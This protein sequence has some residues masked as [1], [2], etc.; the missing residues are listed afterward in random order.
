ML[1]PAVTEAVQEIQ[2]AFSIH[3]IVVD[4][5][6]DGGARVLVEDL[7]IGSPYRQDKSWMGFHI[8]FPYPS[9]D[10]YPHF[11]RAD[12]ARVDGRPLGDGLSGGQSFLGRPSVQISRKSNRLDPRNDTALH[13]MVKVL[14]WLRTRP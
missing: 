11:V 9:S 1:T 2:R 5:D 4:E 8:T 3:P 6:G 13:K 14:E 7:E 12:L 10:V